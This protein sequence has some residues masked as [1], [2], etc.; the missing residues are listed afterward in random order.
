MNHCLPHG[1]PEELLY[2]I[3]CR[4]AERLRQPSVACFKTLFGTSSGPVRWDLPRN[5]S[6]FGRESPP[7]HPLTIRRLISEHTLLNFYRHFVDA[8]M[9]RH[10]RAFLYEGASLPCDGLFAWLTGH[11]V[12]SAYLK[13]CWACVQEDRKMYGETY[14][15]RAH[16]I[17]GVQTCA[18]H[19]AFLATSTIV[20]FGKSY[21][22]LAPRS[23]EQAVQE[24]SLT[25]VDKHK[26]KDVRC[27]ELALLADELLNTHVSGMT[28][29]E[30][31]KHYTARL[32][33]Q[34]LRMPWPTS[35]RLEEYF[36]KVMWIGSG[37]FLG[38]SPYCGLLNIRADYG[39]ETP[40]KIAWL[41]FKEI[42]VMPEQPGPPPENNQGFF[43]DHLFTRQPAETPRRHDCAHHM[44]LDAILA[45]VKALA[46]R[47]AAI[48]QESLDDCTVASP[49]FGRDT[50]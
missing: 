22:Q 33:E 36:K 49:V 28:P 21:S 17:P 27:H 4:F 10:F 43:P 42:G 31:L 34:Q 47:V 16:Q 6:T 5:L 2:S 29:L 40:L 25:L 20:N 46:I 9:L 38:N 30:P 32:A 35:K 50:L 19:Q 11:F 15:H 7:W 14:W 48:K 41:S 12:A 45:E 26:P 44:S 3:C 39:P 24:V 1:Y 37:S 13:Y 8:D 23:A 18:T